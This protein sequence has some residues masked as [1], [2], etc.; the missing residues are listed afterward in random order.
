MRVWPLSC[1]T[2]VY[3]LKQSPSFRVCLVIHFTYNF[4]YLS[5]LFYLIAIQ[6]MLIN[7][8]TFVCLS[9]ARTWISIMS[10][11]CMFYEFRLGVIVLFI[12]MSVIVYRHYL[13]FLFTTKQIRFL[14]LGD[15]LSYKVY[16]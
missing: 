2:F 13:S 4:I 6:Q 8:A 14:F 3:K 10:C 7:S 16:I 12:D 9:Q 15:A 11:F 1:Q 5:T